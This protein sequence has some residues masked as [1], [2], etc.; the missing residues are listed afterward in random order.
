MI[1]PNQIRA[2][3]NFLNLDQKIVAQAV[4]VSGMNISDIE[5]E[6]GSP[7][8]STLKS[9]QT[10]FEARGIKFTERGG[11][12]PAQ[13]YVTIYEGHNSYID[14]LNNAQEQLAR[15]NGEILFSGADERRSSG[16][17]IEK[18][19]EMRTQNVTMRSLI[20]HGDTHIMGLLPEYRWMPES[21]FVEGDVKIIY[22]DRVAYLISWEEAMTRVIEIRDKIIAEEARRHFEFVWTQSEGPDHSTST[23]L[24]EV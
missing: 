4:G 11:I 14:F 17:I 23:V 22:A 5:N 13:N 8:A 16:A 20:R 19:G 3:R 21:L 9:I 2:A 12:E 24:Y 1:R 10:F 15:S 18:L 6:K 7:R